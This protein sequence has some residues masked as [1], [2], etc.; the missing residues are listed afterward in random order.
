M[1][2]LCFYCLFWPEHSARI[3]EWH[4]WV[5][6]ARDTAVLNSGCFWQGGDAGAPLRPV[7]APTTPHERVLV[8][9]P[10]GGRALHRG[11]DLGPALETPA[12]ERQRPEHLP[13][14]L[15][16]VEVGRVLG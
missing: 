14:R 9:V 12:L 1:L 10:V 15:D 8:L 6:L 3:V 7:P 16:Q 5:S 11:L 2:T 13:P 4:Q